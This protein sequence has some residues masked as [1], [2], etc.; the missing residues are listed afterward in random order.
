METI[1]RVFSCTIM[2][3]AINCE[4]VFSSTRTLYTDPI[5][6]QHLTLSDQ[7]GGMDTCVSIKRVGNV[8]KK[9]SIPNGSM[10]NFAAAGVIGR[11]IRG[12]S[13]FNDI[14]NPLGLTHSG[15]VINENPRVIQSIVLSL[16]AGGANYGKYS[17]ALS[18]SAGRA[19]LR[20]LMTYHRDVLAAV[21]DPKIIRG[22]SIE[23]NGSV[24][25]ILSG[26]LPATH[27]Y[28]LQERIEGY[29]GN[30]YVRPLSINVPLESTRDFITRYVGR[31]YESLSTL[32]EIAGSVKEENKAERTENVFC[33]EL[34]ALFYREVCHINIPNVSNI[35]PERFG[36]AAGEYDLLSGIA[37]PEGVLKYYYNFT[38][39]DI[40]GRGLCGCCLG[41]FWNCCF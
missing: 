7:P 9:V 34:A 3:M 20:E 8:F 12:A 40:E 37:C 38:E 36:S 30:V 6:A 19:M 14:P 32:K 23:S 18:N 33:S 15:I 29:D 4:D 25:E 5:D 24:S 11:T 31:P 35:I 41:A 27:I 28:S 2:L 1:F 16:M 10:L 26:I 22:F 17:E 39:D 13:A 21:E